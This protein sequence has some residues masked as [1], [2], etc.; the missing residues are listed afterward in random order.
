MR[1]SLM[2]CEINLNTFFAENM[3]TMINN[4]FHEYSFTKRTDIFFDGGL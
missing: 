3:S 1:T 2:D 4:R